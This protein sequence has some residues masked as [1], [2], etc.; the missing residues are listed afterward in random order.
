[1]V[2][3]WYAL[4]L[5]EC[6]RVCACVCVYQS[7]RIHQHLYTDLRD[8]TT[9]F[10]TTTLD[11]TAVRGVPPN[12]PIF[13]DRT[14]MELRIGFGPVVDVRTLLHD[15]GAVDRVNKHY[16]HD[17]SGTAVTL[18]QRM[19]K[20]TR[21]TRTG[22]KYVAKRS[23]THELTCSSAGEAAIFLA[24]KLRKPKHAPTAAATASA[25]FSA[26][27]EEDGEEDEEEEVTFS[28]EVTRAERDARGRVCAVEL[29]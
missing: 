22:Q 12:T 21:V 6:V 1:M 25:N 3:V 5:S 28:H 7:R 20:Y 4:S 26:P 15:A 19:G 29:E 2:R 9:P 16:L 18:P 10:T 14:H 11:T 23:K 27:Q 8:M 17:G 24:C 13:F